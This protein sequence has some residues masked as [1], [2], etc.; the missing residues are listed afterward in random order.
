MADNPVAVAPASAAAAAAA[1]VAVLQAKAASTDS[2][3]SSEQQRQRLF[4]PALRQA[5]A[6]LGSSSPPAPDDQAS[7]AALKAVFDDCFDPDAIDGRST[8]T[9]TTTTKVAQLLQERLMALHR[10]CA[11]GAASTATEG[12]DDGPVDHIAPSLSVVGDIVRQHAVKN[13]QLLASLGLLKSL[14]S[15]VTTLR[16]RGALGK[17]VQTASFCELLFVLGRLAHH[18][19]ADAS[20]LSTVANAFPLQFDAT[21]T[22]STSPPIL[23][24]PTNALPDPASASFWPRSFHYQAIARYVQIAILARH[25]ETVPPLNDLRLPTATS[26]KERAT[27][28]DAPPPP[29]P[30][31]DAQVPDSARRLFRTVHRDLT[32]RHAWRGVFIPH[33]TYRSANAGGDAAAGVV[34]LS[35]ITWH[36]GA[37]EAHGPGKGSLWTCAR[38]LLAPG[39]R[40]VTGDAVYSTLVDALT[41]A[42]DNAT[43][44]WEDSAGEEDTVRACALGDGGGIAGMVVNFRMVAGFFWV[45]GVPVPEGESVDEEQVGQVSA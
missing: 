43:W 29:P 25:P 41:G 32:A 16:Q 44:E 18:S 4:R 1:L 21:D 38:V 22:G 34:T 24:N 17:A 23:L 37:A 28:P 9:T 20:A 36:S 14:C 19:I 33:P 27:D 42:M 15:I 2:L 10:L 13:L 3:S 35:P 26:E 6:V 45:W 12:G 7:A 8:S 30:P 31:G 5:A 11:E 40:R 39:A